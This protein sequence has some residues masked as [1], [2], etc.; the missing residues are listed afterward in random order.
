MTRRLL[1]IF[2]VAWAGIVAGLVGALLPS[3]E[4]PVAA[5]RATAFDERWPQSAFDQRWAMDDPV[6]PKGDRL[7]RP[8]LEVQPV[9][10]KPVVVKPKEEKR[11]QSRREG[12]CAK[13]KV[14]H[15]RRHWRSWRCRR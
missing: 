13:G 11:E 7:S 3:D 14:W 5:A 15:V 8:A 12:V 6:L 2:S 1:V 9:V 4:P 10:V